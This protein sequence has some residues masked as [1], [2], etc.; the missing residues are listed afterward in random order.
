MRD[1]ACNR[2]PASIR[3]FTVSFILSLHH[4]VVVVVDIIRSIR[5][6][7]WLIVHWCPSSTFTLSTESWCWFLYFTLW[8]VYF[9]TFLHV[10]EYTKHH[11]HKPHLLF[12]RFKIWVSR[13]DIT[14]TIKHL[15]LRHLKLTDDAIDRCEWRE[16]IRGFRRQW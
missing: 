11:P 7:D 10:T 4:H 15:L 8:F 9:F 5:V 12:I 2:G 6:V 13:L 1:P 14:R 3:S 16:V